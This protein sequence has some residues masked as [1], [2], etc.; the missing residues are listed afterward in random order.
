MSTYDK[1]KPTCSTTIDWFWL[2]AT[3]TTAWMRMSQSY[4]CPNSNGFC[5]LGDGQLYALKSLPS[6][7]FG[8]IARSKITLLWSARKKQHFIWKYRSPFWYPG[9]HSFQKSKR[10]LSYIWYIIYIYKCNQ[11]LQ[12]WDFFWFWEVLEQHFLDESPSQ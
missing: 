5:S 2:S 8:W 11:N 10:D 3:K 4:C 1:R 12:S 7:N 9:I 6:G